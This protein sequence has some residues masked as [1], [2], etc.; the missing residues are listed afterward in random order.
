MSSPAATTDD[1]A[2][3]APPEEGAGPLERGLAVLRHL[4]VREGRPTRAGDLARATGLPRS[5]VDRVV[6]TLAHLG[7]LR[8]DDREL[9]P[10]PR[11]LELGDAYLRASRLPALLGPFAEHLA[12]EFDESVSL[13]VP[14]RDGVRF[15][16]QVTRRRTMS[17][18]FRVGD[19]LPAERCA[20]GA[21]FAAAWTDAD[22]RAWRTRLR[23]DPEET[24]FPS[25]PPRRSALAASPEAVEERFAARCA[26][27]AEHGWAEDD[28]FIEPGLVA[29]AVPVRDRS[30]RVVCALSVVSHTSRHTAASLRGLA[31][32]RSRAVVGEMEAALAGAP[33]CPPDDRPLAE[34]PAVDP[35]AAAKAELGPR[36]LQSL[37]RGLAVLTATGGAADGPMPLTAVAEATGLARATAR[38]SLIALERLGYVEAV[39]P[40]FRPT[41]RVL[42]L[43]YAHLSGLGFVEI[44]R[45]HLARLAETV[46]ESASIAVLAGDDIRYVARQP[47]TRI[48]GVDITVG[49]RFPAYPTSMGRVLLAGLP[50][51]ERADRLRRADLV[52]L[53]PRTVTSAD[54][55]AAILERVAREGHAMVDEEL[56]VGLRS[57]AVPLRDRDG[58]VV[59]ALNVAAHAGRGTPEETLRTVLP[60]LREAATAIEA[61]LRAAGARGVPRG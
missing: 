23:E 17:V 15:V 1:P 30:G 59:A 2:T 54:L 12:E 32:A 60:P 46:H 7:Y 21:L 29:L 6:A 22:W 11:L 25:L 34:A 9:R 31:L 61:D 50:P 53:T 41:P 55:L 18:A 3:E 10:R 8:E 49:T 40:G 19:L 14:D 28:Q 24:G 57:V 47:V 44:V 26:A 37:A 5:T 42:E 48:V 20:P 38:R 16:H 33:P 35:T 52:P 45:P 56:E 4:A 27:A 51:A 36:Y 58:T 13:A 39:P 43:G